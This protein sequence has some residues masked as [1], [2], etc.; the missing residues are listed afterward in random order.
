MWLIVYLKS[1]ENWSQSFNFN[2]KHLF[3]LKQVN[4]IERKKNIKRLSFSYVCF[5][6][7]TQFFAAITTFEQINSTAF[8]WYIIHYGIKGERVTK[9]QKKKTNS[10]KTE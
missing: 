10:N 5:D 7:W 4:I 2:N 1:Q 6:D 8:F 3:K 9:K